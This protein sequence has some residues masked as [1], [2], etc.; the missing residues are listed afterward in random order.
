M[1]IVREHAHAI[2]TKYRNVTKPSHNIL[3]ILF[4][5]FD[6]F[7][8]E[9]EVKWKHTHTHILFIRSTFIFIL[10][11]N[12]CCMV[13]FLSD[14][15][16]LGCRCRFLFVF[17]TSFLVSNC[18]QWIKLL[19]QQITLKYRWQLTN[20]V[21]LKWRSE[22]LVSFVVPCRRCSCYFFFSFCR[23]HF[24]LTIKLRLITTRSCKSNCL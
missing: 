10:L 24:E 2:H 22:C 19:L 20:N 12:L 21:F 8:I 13:C 1:H 16:R 14:F 18:F 9:I 6:F 15:G 5:S 11:N 17:S 4:F 3:H 23:E 7:S